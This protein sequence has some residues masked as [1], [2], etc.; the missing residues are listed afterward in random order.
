MGYYDEDRTGRQQRSSKKSGYFLSSL[1]GLIVGALLVLIALPKLADYNLLPAA[2]NQVEVEQNQKPVGKK[3]SLDI[4]TDVTKAVNKAKNTVVGITNIQSG[5]FWEGEAAQPAGTGSG[6]IYKKTGDK[7]YI[8]TNY[9]VVEGAQQLEVS[10]A[11][12]TKIPAKVRGGDM[13]TDLAVVEVDSSKITDVAEFGD[14]DA[15]KAGEPVIAIGNPLGLE[16]SGS[17][18]QGVISGLERAVPVDINKDGMVDWQAEVLQTD[19]A[20]NP[21]NSG[22]ALVNISGQ[23]IGINSMKIAE[24]SIEGIG[25]SIPINYAEPII[26]NLEKY[27]KVKRPA[28]GVTLRNVNEIPAYHQQETLKLPANV[29][30]GAMIEAVMP[31]TPASKAGLQELDVIVQLD[32]EKITDILALRKYMYTHKKIGDKVEVIFYRDGQK[33]KTTMTLSSEGML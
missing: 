29:K 12:G 3:V 20:I 21:G 27:G 28:M 24:Q 30:D 14:S 13:W 31:G 26:G 18:T 9:H 1:V 19:A 25:L 11:D 7:A 8:V 32:N 4:T 5:S 16:F 10:L 22:G 33:Q 2:G 6:V 17:V 23:V 15:L